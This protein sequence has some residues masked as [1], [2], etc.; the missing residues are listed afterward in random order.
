MRVVL[1]GATGMVGQ[2]VLRECLL[3]PRV[4]RIVSVGRRTVGQ[5]HDKLREIVVHDFANLA[6]VQ[7]ELGGFDACFFCLGTSSL[8]KSERD[9][10]RI[11][12]D[13]ALAAGTLLAAR[14][15]GMTFVFVSGA[16]ADGTGTSRLMWARV[17]GE[18]E[19]ALLALPFK[20]VYVFR[21]GIVRPV[22]GIRSRTSWINLAY[23]V[24]RPFMPILMRIAPQT[25]T[26]SEQMGRA[27][28]VAAREGA[29][30]RVL[31][32]G[33]INDLAARY[34]PPPASARG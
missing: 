11:T 34:Q 5:P 18:A 3:D 4:V 7:D 17:K 27:M 1:F 2:G 26:T 6:P 12:C 10:R 32:N 16:G 15:P 22:D 13:Y 20:A 29:A 9:Y 25:V 14:N 21:P 33:D 23:A 24:S 30:S 31:E 28:I 19:N 8:G